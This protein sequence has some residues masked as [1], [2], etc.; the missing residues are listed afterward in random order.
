MK[1]KMNGFSLIELLIV[2]AIVG[3]LAALATSISTN[4]NEKARL[5]SAKTM[6][7]E[8]QGKQERAA[9]NQRRYVSL[10]SLGYSSPL[11]INTE[12]NS[13]PQAQAFYRIEMN[14]PDNFTF[15]ITATP[16]NGQANNAC[17]VLTIN[18]K[19]EKTATGTNC[20]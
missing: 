1:P 18:N 3:I 12:G 8:I 7:I 5:A 2:V 14:V 16:I 4:S 13:S 9:I 10:T 19:G 15:T 11:F 17:G 20:W 6:M